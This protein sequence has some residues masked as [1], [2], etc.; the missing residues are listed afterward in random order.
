M[1][2]F[3]G[4]VLFNTTNSTGTMPDITVGGPCALPVGA[5]QLMGPNSTNKLCPLL[6]HPASEPES[7][8]FKIDRAAVEQVSDAALEH[9]ECDS[10]EGVP[11]A[12]VFKKC[13]GHRAWFVNQSPGGMPP[14]S[15]IFPLLSALVLIF[16]LT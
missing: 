11:P 5:A 1:W 6:Q 2:L 8:A 4:F 9:A 14:L 12:S 7:C 16:C 3:D 15:S 10:W 13:S